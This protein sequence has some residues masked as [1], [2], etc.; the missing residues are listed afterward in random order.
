M[1]EVTP[2]SQYSLML[3]E[4]N[5]V[6]KRQNK[7]YYSVGLGFSSA[8]P[9]PLSTTHHQT[10]TPVWNHLLSSCAKKNPGISWKEHVPFLYINIRLTPTQLGQIGKAILKIFLTQMVGNV[11]KINATRCNAFSPPES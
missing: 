7:F 10:N 9:K 4:L 2:R 11:D 5:P 1:R 6:R 8:L 3:E